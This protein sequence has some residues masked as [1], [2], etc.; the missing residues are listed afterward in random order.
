MDPFARYALV[1]AGSPLIRMDAQTILHEA[2]YRVFTVSGFEDALEILAMR[3]HVLKLLFT[4]EHTPPGMKTGYD[5]ARRCARDWPDIA[6]VV[7]CGPTAIP[8]GGGDLPGGAV[9]LGKPDLEPEQARNV[10]QSAFIQRIHS[11]GTLARRR[12][13]GLHSL[14][15]PRS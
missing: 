4:E 14:S 5:L 2:G 8:P 1:V 9:F 6:I 13:A 3:G 12:V 10:T 7:S 11:P 15:H